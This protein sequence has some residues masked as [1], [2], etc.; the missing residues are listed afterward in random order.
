MAQ[1]SI[2]S[3]SLVF[4]TRQFYIENTDPNTAKGSTLTFEDLD[5][6]L[7][8]LSS[9]VASASGAS[10]TTAVTSNIGAG[11]ISSGTTIPI[12]TTFQ[13][14][15]QQLLVTYIEPTITEVQIWYNSSQILT[16]TYDVGDSFT[17]DGVKWSETA[18]SP[19]DKFPEDYD[20]I[21]ITIDGT[22][23]DAGTSFP[24]YSYTVSPSQLINKNTVTSVSIIV[25][26]LDKN[27]STVSGAK[28]ISFSLRNQFGG[29]GGAIPTNDS[30]AQTLFNFL[31]GSQINVFDNNKAFNVIC[32]GDYTNDPANYT[33]IVYPSTYGT[34]S[35]IIQNGATPVLGAFTSLGT[36]NINNGY[37]Y[38]YSV[39]IY[40]SNALGAFA[41]GVTLVIT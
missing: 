39:Y 24:P 20:N 34:L 4:K 28:T 31:T 40:K 10:L 33:Y 41:N 25:D 7:L 36:F 21:Y 29:Y 5:K 18:D 6:T 17:I 30:Q 15:V 14:F 37:G 26:G 23:Y 8:F 1:T 16:S 3:S 27:S 12:G 9:S 11:A 13:Q 19:D 38:S 2:P 35:N 32:D 22:S